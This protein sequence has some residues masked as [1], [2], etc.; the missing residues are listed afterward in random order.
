LRNNKANR[1]LI[2][3]ARRNGVSLESLLGEIELA[4]AIGM[5]DPDPAAQAFWRSV[6]RTGDRPTP[7]ELVEYIAG[8]EQLKR[9]QSTSELASS[10]NICH[11]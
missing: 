8:M 6:P 4:I 7:A 11:A 5:A 1:A 10:L 2:K 9:A 3:A